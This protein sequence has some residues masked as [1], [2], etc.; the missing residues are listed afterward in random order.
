MRLHKFAPTTLSFASGMIQK[1]PDAGA[2]QVAGD[3]ATGST[4]P[5]ASAT[6]TVSPSAQETNN[7]PLPYPVCWFEDEDTQMALR[8]HI[9]VG[10]LW[11]MKTQRSL[12]WRIRLHFTAYPSSQI[13]PLDTDVISQVQYYYKN[14][15]KQALCIQY[16]N[17]KVA[18]NLTKES[19]SKL[20]E[21]VC[22]TNLNLYNSVHS[23]TDMMSL[24]HFIPIRLYLSNQSAPIQRSC[25]KSHDGYTRTLGTCLLEWLPDLFSIDAE[26]NQCIVPSPD[27]ECWRVQGIQVP[28]HVSLWELWTELSHP[29]HFCYIIVITR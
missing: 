10:T 13:L 25:P 17:S 21:A 16:G 24:D 15:L 29:D 28:L 19:H 14:S 26:N 27:V 12:P 8:W 23:E 4:S 6:G 3:G 22:T 9:F 1:E 7:K 20:W 11:D 18:M 2:I 5:S